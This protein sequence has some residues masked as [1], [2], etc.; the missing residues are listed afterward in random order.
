M[1]HLFPNVAELRE[2]GVSHSYSIWQSTVVC[3]WPDENK[4]LEQ[5]VLTI[6]DVTSLRSIT[7]LIPFAEERALFFYSSPSKASKVVNLPSIATQGMDIF[8]DNWHP[9]VK[10][11]DTQRSRLEGWISMRIAFGYME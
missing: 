7:R 8:L 5:M 1:L 6:A 4:G 10:T 3:D 2:S 11:I 9:M